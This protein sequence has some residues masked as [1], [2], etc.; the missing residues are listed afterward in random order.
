M[1]IGIAGGSFN[2]I[3]KGHTRLA[4]YLV[5]EQIVDLVLLMP[6]YKSLYNK[7]L[8]SGEDRLKMIELSNRL[9]PVQPFDW[10]IKNKIEGIGTYDVMKMLEKQLCPWDAS[11]YIE[12]TNNGIIL[13]YGGTKTCGMGGLF[14]N[15]EIYFIIGLD[16]SQKVKT[17]L[18]GDRITKEFKFIVVP[19]K[20]VDTKDV[21]FMK[22]PHIFVDSYE[23][24]EISS[25]S[26]KKILAQ[27]A[28]PKEMLDEAVYDYIIRY[29]LYKDTL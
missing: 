13:R 19:R 29:N 6:C 21:W 9:P 28:N 12:R 20:G 11:I 7:E 17:W 1:R 8:A 24:D 25:T 18:N 14:E 22:P 10:E 3:T 2:P 26:V 16:N 15:N 4:N 23:P 5:K 27:E